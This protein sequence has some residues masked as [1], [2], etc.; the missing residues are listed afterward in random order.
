MSGLEL[1][2]NSVKDISNAPSVVGMGVA[3][4]IWSDEGKTK[5][6]VR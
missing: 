5:E 4:L 2:R 1:E 6:V 3:Y